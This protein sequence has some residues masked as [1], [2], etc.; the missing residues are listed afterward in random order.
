MSCEL[1]Y[2]WIGK[3]DFDCIAQVAKHCD[4]NKL[5]IYIREQQN[6]S[7]LPKIGQCLFNKLECYKKYQD[8]ID[9]EGESCDDCEFT[10]EEQ[11]IL[12]NLLCGG[13][14]EG[15]DGQT[16]KHFGIQRMLVHYAY[17]SYAYRHGYT[18]TPFGIVQKANQDS[19]PA[20]LSEL[21][22]IMQEHQN[23]AEYYWKMTQDYLCSIKDDKLIKDCIDCKK[24]KYLCNHCTGGVHTEQNRGMSFRTVSRW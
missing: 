14:Y 17:G 20:P 22:K 7:L 3:D 18:D 13:I 1:E 11:S 5:C 4:W 8:C 19:L 21:R 2:L 9:A 24:C 6:L 16:K 15:C 12:K 23:N 10:G